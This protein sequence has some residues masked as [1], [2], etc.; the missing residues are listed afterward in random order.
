MKLDRRGFIKSATAVTAGGMLVPMESL[1]ADGK[2]T[3]YVVHGN[4]PAKMLDAAR[5]GR[6]V[7]RL[8]SGDASVFGRGADEMD[9]LRKAGI[10]FEVVPG[11]TAGL[12]V[13]GFCEIPVTH[14]AA[15]SAVA[16]VTGRERDEK[17]ALQL[18]RGLAEFPGT[19]VF[20]MGVRKAPEWSKALIAQ[21][22]PAD[23]PV[24]IVRWCSRVEQK[25]VTC[26]LATVSEAIDQHAIR[27]PALFVVGSVV[28]HA[29][30]S[31][32]SAARGL[33]RRPCVELDLGIPGDQGIVEKTH[34]L[35][36][37]RN[38][39]RSVGVEDRVRAE[40]HV[41]RGFVGLQANS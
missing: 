27:P 6:S 2:P 33:Q 8:K 9:A 29:Q 40:G 34:V 12:A 22:K 19:L 41:P 25:T 18:A 3:I 38:D 10:P 35:E 15:A 14:H 4:D 30:R 32:G 31:Q 28:D 23:T 1:S 26:T 11:I 39:Q 5:A 16:L 37:V 13:A 21:G 7:V 20:Y 17:S 24:A 36:G